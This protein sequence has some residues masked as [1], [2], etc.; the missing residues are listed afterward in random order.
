MSLSPDQLAE[1]RREFPRRNRHE[2][3]AAWAALPRPIRKK[4]KQVQKAMRESTRTMQEEVA[5]A[6]D[7]ASKNSEIS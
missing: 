1:L 5:K 3:R 7:E 6:I 4:L 2:R